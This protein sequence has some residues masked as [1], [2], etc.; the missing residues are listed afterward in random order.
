MRRHSRL[1]MITLLATVIAL[2]SAF[3]VQAGLSILTTEVPA[4]VTVTLASPCGDQNG[5]EAVDILDTIIDFQINAGL[6]EPSL[7]QEVLSD[8]DQDGIISVLDAMTGMQ[9]VLGLITTLSQCGL[10]SP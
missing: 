6:A 2:G 1:C 4:S 7:A 8:L 10:P 9:H 5:D 3:A